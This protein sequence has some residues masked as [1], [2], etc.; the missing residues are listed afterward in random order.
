MDPI[1]VLGLGLSAGAITLATVAPFGFLIEKLFSP[2][3][4]ALRRGPGPYIDAVYWVIAPLSAT[5]GRLI[6]FLLL[7]LVL[8]ALSVEGI[9]PLDVEATFSKVATGYGPVRTLA[10]SGPWGLTA[11][12]L[13]TLL[14]F[15]FFAYWIH[16]YQHRSFLWP[17]HAIHHSPDTLDFLATQRAHPLDHIANGVVRIFPLAAFGFPLYLSAPILTAVSLH[18]V[19]LHGATRWRLGP[20][21]YVLN[22]PR[23]H[24]WH[25]AKG[26]PGGVNFGVAL[27]VWDVAFGTYCEPGVDPKELGIDGGRIAENMLLQ[28][29]YPFAPRR[30]LQFVEKQTGAAVHLEP[31][32]PADEVH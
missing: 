10:E 7:G 21:R 6:A 5:A 24:H 18:G 2:D 19:L 23:A 16:R 9:A 28:M 22:H 26:K 27:L 25:H 29:A 11:G 3:G 12:L 4:R 20:L 1:F 17:I 14:V 8:A 30:L 13:L 31:G 32:A 15:E